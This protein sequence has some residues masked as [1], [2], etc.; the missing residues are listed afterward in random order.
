V[1]VIGCFAIGL[2]CGWL[3]HAVFSAD[4]KQ[5]T[6]LLLVT[7]VCGGFTT[8]STFALDAV[9]YFEGGNAIAGLTYIF[10][11]LLLGVVLCTLGLWIGA[12][13]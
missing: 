4:F 6:S 8:F 10:L 7:G 5:G 12:K 13:I 11:S 3:S 2:I 1:N 9:K